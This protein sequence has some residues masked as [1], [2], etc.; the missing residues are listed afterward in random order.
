L[1]SAVPCRAPPVTAAI[2]AGEGSVF[3]AVARRWL[4]KS[5]LKHR[6]DR[7]IG[8]GG[9]ELAS[10]IHGAGEVR[11]GERPLQRAGAD[12]ADQHGGAF[13]AGGGF[14]IDHVRAETEGENELL[15]VHSAFDNF[16]AGVAVEQRI[17]GSIG[18][19][20]EIPWHV[21]HAE[22]LMRGDE[23]DAA[24]AEHVVD[25]RHHGPRH[26]QVLEHA[27]G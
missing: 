11:R 9:G 20:P 8:W 5:A 14:G 2:L 16:E 26:H 13:K 17:P 10:R 23:G 19:P 7:L 12:F 22:G 4:G 21:V 3:R 1:K 6:H 18:K 25:L 24:G 15:A 27:D